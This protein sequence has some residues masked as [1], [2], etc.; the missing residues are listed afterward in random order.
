MFQTGT[1]T[2]AQCT[3]SLCTPKT[4]CRREGDENKPALLRG[5][6]TGHDLPAVGCR[7]GYCHPPTKG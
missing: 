4:P 3:V 5:S 1:F 2:D 6:H 7:V